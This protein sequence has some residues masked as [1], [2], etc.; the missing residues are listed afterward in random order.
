MDNLSSACKFASAE[1]VICLWLNYAIFSLFVKLIN[2]TGCS[3]SK[4]LN[5]DVGTYIF[6]VSKR[7][8]INIYEYVYQY[9][10]NV[11]DNVSLG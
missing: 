4:N 9:L 11:G 7:K 1:L 6:A 2:A 8:Q 5:K 10:R 3:Q